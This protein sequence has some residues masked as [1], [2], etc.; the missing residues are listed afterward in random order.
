M[1]INELKKKL[2]YVIKEYGI[3][4]TEAYNVSTRIAIE[5]DKIYNKNTVQSYYNESLDALTNYI[6]ENEINPSEVRWNKY[7][8]ENRYLSSETM[9]YI[10]G[11]G[12]NKLCKELRKELK[13]KISI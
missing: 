10:Y 3:N 11:E 5:I 9:G 2:E 8:V 1:V 7:A 4:S 13:E 6:K 12:F